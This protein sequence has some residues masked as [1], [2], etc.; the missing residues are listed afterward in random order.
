[1][2]QL[3]LIPKSEAMLRKEHKRT[4]RNIALYKE[5][6]EKAY[7]MGMVREETIREVRGY[8]G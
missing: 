5:T 2:N 7:R 3:N 6:F 4:A 1:M 8:V